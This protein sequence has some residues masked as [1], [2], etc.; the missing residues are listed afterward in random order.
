MS[1]GGIARAVHGTSPKPSVRVAI[2]GA[3]GRI[4]YAS[5]FHLASGAVLGA[6]QPVR[7]SL[8][9]SAGSFGA[10]AGLAMELEDCAFPALQA[11]DL[12]ESP[13]AAFDQVDWALLIGAAAR[14]PGMERSQLLELNAPI[15]RRQGEAL[16]EA[17]AEGARVLVVGNPANTNALVV[18]GSAPNL[19]DRSVTALTRLDHNRAVG[20][21]ARRVGAPTGEVK[22]MTVWGNH[23]PTEYTDVSHCVVSGVPARTAVR[24][25]DWVDAVLVDAVG[26][27][28]ADVLVARGLG[29]A[30]S[31]ALAAAQHL[32]DW[33]HGTPDGDWTSAALVSDGSYGIPYGLV[34]SVPAVSVGGRFQVVRGLE[35]ASASRRRLA[36]SVDELVDECRRV[37]RLGLPVRWQDPARLP[38]A[39]R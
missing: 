34:C 5:A 39:T 27:R 16:N 37:E 2:T 21:L 4:G 36:V 28:G 35:L 20:M 24:D 13:R 6:D 7:L 18:R 25:D 23:S 10:L 19:P 9:G 33:A 31:A 32:A 14:R 38:E 11:V 15:F 12:Y 3:A 1:G 22:R 30:G 29:S 8:L 17:A 26:R